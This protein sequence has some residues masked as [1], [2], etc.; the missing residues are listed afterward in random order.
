MEE[1][2]EAG[3]RRKREP[4]GTPKPDADA[5]TGPIRSCSISHLSYPDRLKR[6]GLY[7]LERRRDRYAI[8]YIYTIL[9]GVAP[10]FE[11][12]QY[13]IIT[14]V[15]DRRGLFCRKP[16]IAIRA[17]DRIKTL[18]DRSLA[19]RGPTLFNALPKNLRQLERSV[20]AF[21]NNLDKH[22]ADVPDV[23]S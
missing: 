7:S 8:I 14:Y 21:K 17:A 15:N 13:K 12:D 18:K 19:V 11:C 16:A 1:E 20:E 3:D 2:E 22:L 10:N 9:I 4:T 5:P 6:L 23:P